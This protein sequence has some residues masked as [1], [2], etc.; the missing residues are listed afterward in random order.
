MKKLIIIW[1]FCFFG[2]PGNIVAQSNVP[3]PS[4]SAVNYGKFAD[5]EPNLYNGSLNVP[6][7]IGG[8]SKGTVSTSV[9]INYHTSGIRTAELAS[10]VGL[11]WHLN[12][13]GAI[14]RQVK[15]LDDFSTKGWLITGDQVQLEPDPPSHTFMEDVENG[16]IDPEP[17]V[18]TFQAGGLSG[19][20]FFNSSGG[21]ESLP[22]SELRIEYFEDSFTDFSGS[23]PW[24]TYTYDYFLIT[25]VDG[26]KYY[27]GS[28]IDENAAIPAIRNEEYV[29]TFKSAWYLFKIESYDSEHEILFS[30]E[31][32]YY[33]FYSLG[34]CGF[35]YAQGDCT[36]SL[37]KSKVR[38]KVLKKISSATDDISLNYSPR[39][40]LPRNDNFTTHAPKRLSNITIQKGGKLQSI[41][42]DNDQ[43]FEGNNT[44]PN[45]LNGSVDNSDKDEINRRLKLNGLTISGAGTSDI[46]YAFTYYG[47]NESSNDSFFPNSVSLSYDHWGYY[48]EKNVIS[49]KHLIP[50]TCVNGKCGGNTNVNRNSI[51][52]ASVVGSLE[53]ITLPTGGKTT[54]KYQPNKYGSS[55]ESCGGLRVFEIKTTASNAA[56]IKRNYFYSDG[57]LYKVPKYAGEYGVGNTFTFFHS[58]G[59]SLLRNFDGYHIGYEKVTTNYNGNGKKVVEFHTE[60]APPN[61]NDYPPAV[62]DIRFDAG[63]P[64][65]TEIIR[66]SGTTQLSYDETTLDNAVTTTSAD[67]MLTADFFYYAGNTFY[68]ERFYHI[69]HKVKRPTSSLHIKE[70][71]Q[72]S[73]SYEYFSQAFRPERITAFDLNN[74]EISS[75]DIGYTSGYYGDNSSS[76]L[77]YFTDKNINIPWVGTQFINTQLASLSETH[78]KQFAIFG[79]FYP[80]RTLVKHVDPVLSGSVDRT[81]TFHSYNDGLLTKFT[82]PGELVDEEFTYNAN[83]TLEEHCIGTLCTNY[84]YH[85]NSSLLQSSTRVD[86]TTTTYDYD[87]QLRLS[88]KTNPNGSSENYVYNI[89]ATNPYTELVE[90]FT[91]PQPSLSSLSSRTSRQYMDGLGR[92][93]QTVGIQQ[94][95]SGKDQISAVEYDDQGRVIKKFETFEKPTSTSAHTI[96]SGQVFTETIYEP[97]PLNRVDQNCPPSW[98]NKCM[99]YA[100]G[101]NTVIITGADGISYPNGSLFKREVVDMNGNIGQTFTDIRGRT[102]LKRRTNGMLNTD[103]NYDYDSKNRLTEVIPPGSTIGNT[104]LNFLYQYDHLNN[105][106]SKKIPSA[107]IVDYVYDDR[108]LM[109]GYQDGHLRGISKWYA[110]KYDN[111]GREINSGIH[112]SQPTSTSN[113]NDI[114]SV[115]VFGNSGIENG[116]VKENYSQ[117]LGTGNNLISLNTYDS[118][119]RLSTVQS[120]NVLKLSL[121]DLTTFHYDGADNIVKVENTTDDGNGNVTE[122]I[123]RSSIDDDGRNIGN[124]LDVDFG[125]G[126]VT[127]QL[128]ELTYTE[129][130]QVAI[131]YQGGN[132]ANNLQRMDHK[133]LD[134]GFLESVNDGGIFL[135]LFAYTLYYFQDPS[136]NTGTDQYNGNIKSTAWRSANENVQL[137]TYSYDYLDRLKTVEYAELSAIG[138]GTP[139]N[140]GMYN[141]SY[142]YD[143]RGNFDS[144]T[145]Y[146]E[147]DGLAVKIDDLTYN[148][149]ATK[150][151]QLKAVTESADVAKG[152]K[153]ENDSD[154]LYDDNGNMIVDPQKGT[155]TI[156]NHLNLAEKIEWTDGRKLEFLYD[157]FG[158]LIERKNYNSGGS[159]LDTRTYLGGIEYLNGKRY[160]IMHSE[161]RIVNQSVGAFTNYLFLDHQ[162]QIN[163]LFEAGIIDSEGNIIIEYTDYDAG[164]YIQL[165]PEF[166][167]IL[168]AEFTAD[169]EPPAPYVEDWQWEWDISDH[170]GNLRMTYSD[171]DGNGTIDPNT[172]I[173]QRQDYHAYGLRRK[174][175]QKSQL[176]NTYQYNSIDHVNDFGL[177]LNMAT[178]RSLDPALGIWGQVDPKAEANFGLSPYNSLNNNPISYIDPDGDLPFLA[179]VGIG[180]AIGGFGGGISS[181]NNGGSFWGGFAKGALI[182][183]ATSA[184]TFGIGSAFGSVGGFANELGRAGA[185]GL[186]NGV[187]SELSGGGFGSGFLSGAVSSGFGTAFNG[188]DGIGAYGGGALSGGL[189]SLA[190]G[191]NFWVGAGQGLAVSALNHQSHGDPPYKSSCDCEAMITAKR[192]NYIGSA[193]AVASWSGALSSSIGYNM[194][195]NGSYRGA[196]GNYYSIRSQG[197]NQFTGAK[198]HMNN[199]VSGANIAANINY[200]AGA[201]SAGLNT[202]QWRTGQLSTAAY[203]IEM[204]STGVSTFAKNPVGVI[205]TAGYEGL[206]RQIYGRN[207]LGIRSRVK[208]WLRNVFGYKD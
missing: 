53:S 148:Y 11:G 31:D 151:N 113:I 22:N 150:P 202:Y 168:G 190:G 107:D 142:N 188:L 204:F 58:R 82:K 167:V 161:G 127:Q 57:V 13:G 104:G 136:H 50:F 205:W 206:G 121:N 92:V 133:Y 30:Y 51:F 141:T 172:E 101:T 147:Q 52:G 19:K 63:V 171:L 176:K 134:N 24:P 86:G 129:K 195:N 130:D 177:D 106:K 175:W 75:Q 183:G 40:D 191:G 207:F 137:Q 16:D 143:V 201:I 97:S 25:G 47:R 89:D 77:P 18:F 71:V 68:A 111:Y 103:T 160:A 100:Y 184:A 36:M 85:G 153:K 4:V 105:I 132:S 3:T 158:G 6:I 140:Q 155:T 72:S 60:A 55:N 5:I 152:Y 12:A 46:S 44:F 88:S 182:G 74:N 187:S 9:S 84:T 64:K 181:A 91:T 10:E 116:K 124:W 122:V 73:K 65:S 169:I 156:Y 61:N 70:G 149:H 49:L 145:R 78:F 2:T 192:T 125:S 39:L 80:S 114:H 146:E 119:G 164:E 32:H 115:T 159:L 34:D 174:H 162:Q 197:W 54:F 7:P 170:L 37:S 135:D 126:L 178:Y 48:N 59:Y 35:I 185:H 193:A 95:Y 96:P 194:V 166:E 69:S 108:D 157:A 198:A 128:S 165:L 144:L 62:E 28:Y 83:G 90:N 38:G 41:V 109:I 94:A 163:G 33:Q 27:F 99:H 43:Y 93:I 179:V 98:D 56:T 42:F 81:T 117:I 45:N 154:Y 23:I 118:F 131:K 189:S 110:Y 20:F 138:S 26:T 17:D 8:V 87:N 66:G 1:A 139:L 123:N 120:N 173:I 200:G 15:G 76:A 203:G 102:I 186:V 67:K 112:T 208:P 29:E 199:M 196:S 21:I 79:E 180:A 14:T